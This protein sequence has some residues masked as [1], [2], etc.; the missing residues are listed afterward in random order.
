MNYKHPF[1]SCICITGNRPLVL[2]RAII[3]FAR[4]DYPNTEL[5]I[6]Y[7]EEDLLS[8]AIIDQISSVITIRIVTVLRP[9]NEKPCLTKNK[10]IENCNGDYVCF[11]ND[12]HWHHVNRL[13]DQYIVIKDGPFKASILMHVLLYD[14]NHKK[15]YQSAYNKWQET[16]FCEKKIL[17]EAAYS[18]IEREDDSSIL[19]FLSYKNFLYHFTEASHLYIYIGYEIKNKNQKL[20]SSYCENGEITE[21]INEIVQDVIQLEHYLNS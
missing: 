7:P 10:A 4:Q 20:F 6:S 12:E 13:S 8:K 17:L 5:I 19:H 14:F 11:W 15:T 3:C 18:D 1:I 2:Q 21:E 16:L 9:Q